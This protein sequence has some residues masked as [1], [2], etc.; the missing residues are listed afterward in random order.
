[1]ERKKLKDVYSIATNRIIEHL[2]HGTVPWR[3]PWTG[4]GLPRNLL[5]KKPYRGINLWMLN[6]EGYTRNY[7]LTFK[8]AK[9]IGTTIKTGEKA[10]P[11]L[12]W[13]WVKKEKNDKRPLEELAAKDL[14]PVLRYYMVFN[15]DQCQRLPE[16][17]VPDLQRPN[18]PLLSCEGILN[19]MATPP[20]IIHKMHKA[21][22]YPESDVINMPEIG[23]F[24]N[25][26]AY[27]GTLFHELTH[28]TGHSS[29]LNRKELMDNSSFGSDR[30]SLEELTAEIG[31]SYLS[32]YAGI[33]LDDFA[34]SAAYVEGWL[35]VL[36]NDRKFI[37]YASAQA[38]RAVEF[39]LGTAPTAGE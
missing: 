4:S 7:F 37:V 32:S 13:K 16:G 25:S 9:E 11:V 19:G 5:T 20:D 15:V 1:M 31:A 34:N 39:I 8:Q 36:K 3:K 30:Y 17:I 29:R 6:A 23:T 21:C 14:K 24:E 28:S 22:Y 35:K 2:E 18:A 33:M 12:F 38:Q 26:E 27:Y 10:H